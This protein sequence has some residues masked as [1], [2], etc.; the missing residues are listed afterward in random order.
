AFFRYQPCHRAKAGTAEPEKPYASDLGSTS[1]HKDGSRTMSPHRLSQRRANTVA[2][3][4]SKKTRCTTESEQPAPPAATKPSR[5]GLPAEGSI[6][7]EKKFKSPKGRVY[8]IIKTS[9]MDPGDEPIPKK[10]RKRKK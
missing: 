10:K 5:Q 4:R 8:R 6:L 9:E 3:S 7:S 2:H 1:H